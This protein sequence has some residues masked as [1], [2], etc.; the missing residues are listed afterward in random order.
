M[1]IQLCFCLIYTPHTCLKKYKIGIILHKNDI[2]NEYVIRFVK[3][4]EF[5]TLIDIQNYRNWCDVIDKIQECELIVSS[6]LHGIIFS[7]AYKVPNVWVKFS[8]ETFDGSFK[9]LDY[10]MSV[11]R[12]ERVPVK[13]GENMSLEKM[14]ELREAY[15][16][17]SF[18]VAPLLSVCPFLSK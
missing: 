3:E 1:V 4:N 15:I 17:I 8:D 5:V 16:P 14:Y 13:W 2:G 11:G 9:Y 7:D 10:M 18:D 6:S 12:Q